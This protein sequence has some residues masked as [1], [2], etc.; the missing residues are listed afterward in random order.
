MRDVLIVV[1]LGA[2][3]LAFR[4][5]P[6][7]AHARSASLPS[8]RP[9]ASEQPAGGQRDIELL[10]LAVLTAL[11]VPGAFSVDPDNWAI[12]GFAAAAAALVTV[13]SRRPSL[14]LVISASVLTAVAVLFISGGFHV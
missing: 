9:A 5:G 10:P 12:G 1:G 13:L 14:F 4:I 7:L 3:T 6:A 11:V 2:L 8:V